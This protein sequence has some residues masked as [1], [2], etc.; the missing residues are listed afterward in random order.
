LLLRFEDAPPGTLFLDGADLRSL[1]ADAVRSR[2]AWVAQRPH[3]FN[4]TLRDNLLLARPGADAPLRAAALRRA[5]LFVES[6]REGEETWLGEEGQRLSGGERQRLAVARA[7]LRD[8]PLLLLDEPTAH[9]DAIAERALFAEIQR[10]ARG[11]ATLFVTH[12]VRGLEWVD[13][14]VVLSKG[15][16]AERGR[17]AE[18]AAGGGLFSRMLEVQRSSDLLERPALEPQ[19]AST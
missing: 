15:R 3:V 16:V 5:G 6:W 18:L 1:S 17:F 9:L 2:I 7:F 4:A 10:S 13:E 14:I 8:A 19:S 12:R 11:R